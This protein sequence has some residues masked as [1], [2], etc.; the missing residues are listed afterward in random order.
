MLGVGSVPWDK[1]REAATWTAPP[2]GSQ[3]GET[4]AGGGR[5]LKLPHLLWSMPHYVVTF[6]GGPPALSLTD[7]PQWAHPGWR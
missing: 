7:G 3:T 2:V 5:S 1:R 4:P 6:S